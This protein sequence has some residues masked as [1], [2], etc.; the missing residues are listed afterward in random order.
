MNKKTQKPATKAAKTKVEAPADKKAASKEDFA[1]N[2]DNYKWLI[3]GVLAVVLGF[4]LMVGGGS[5]DPTVFKG[6]E[7]FSPVRMTI[8]PIL[9]LAGYVVVIFAIMKKPKAGQE[10]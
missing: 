1:F 8:A 2:R 5:D 6:E 9:I 3:I 10:S 4:L 7:L